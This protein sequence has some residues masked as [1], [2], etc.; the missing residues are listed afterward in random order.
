MMISKSEFQIIYHPLSGQK[1]EAI[2][3]PFRLLLIRE[4]LKLRQS[5]LQKNL[6]YL[7]DLI[8]QA[9]QSLIISTK[10]IKNEF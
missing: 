5:P 1:I 8:Q 6:H 7:H 4:C 9:F 10:R 2:R 3:N